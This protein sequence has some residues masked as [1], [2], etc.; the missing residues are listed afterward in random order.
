M[1]LN[2][3]AVGYTSRKCKYPCRCFLRCFNLQFS[4]SEISSCTTELIRFYS[5]GIFF[6]ILGVSVEQEIEKEKKQMSLEV[7]NF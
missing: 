3:S 5:L 4:A 7:I 2:A 6:L 1:F